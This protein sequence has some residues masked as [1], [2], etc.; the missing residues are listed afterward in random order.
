MNSAAVSRFFR[1]RPFLIALCFALLVFIA[2]AVRD[3]MGLQENF[4]TKG[5]D[6]IMRLVTVRDWLA[7]QGWFDSTQY[8]ILP[9]EGMPLHWSRYIDAG[10]AAIILPLTLFVPME[11][12][13]QIA[14][15]IW[16]TLIF[17]LNLFV[18]AYGTRRL[19]GTWAACS[20]MLCMVF[21]PL[22]GDLHSGAGNLDHH[23]VQ[24]LM[25]SIVAL[26]I[27]WPERAVRAGLIG[28]VAAAFS[29][30]VGL[31]SLP[32]VVCAGALVLINAILSGTQHGRQLL[33]SF[34]AALGASSIVFWLGQTVPSE[35]FNP[36]CDRLAT[37]T[38]ALVGIAVVA[39]VLPFMF[40]RL[41]S[42]PL[43][44]ISATVALTAIGVLIAWPLLSPCL[45]GP[46]GQLP[47]E[48][49]D[50]I[51]GK[52]TE[53]KPIL[54]Y[55]VERPGAT[56]VFFLP[57]IVAVCFGTVLWLKGRHAPQSDESNTAALGP[58]LV[59]ILAGIAMTFVQM[60]T[61]II[62]GSVVPIVGGY[63]I[64]RFL[65]AYLR[66]RQLTPALV[67]L[68]VALSL[69]SPSTI[70]GPLWPLLRTD[71]ADSSDA[72]NDC[73]SYASLNTL[74]EVPPALVLTHINFG[75]ALIWA[76]HHFGLAAPYHRSPAAFTN[77]IVPFTFAEEEME[78]YVRN[79]GATHL[80][81][82]RGYGYESAFVSDLATGGSVDWLRR[83]VVSNDAQLLFEVLP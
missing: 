60:R 43:L 48:V 45:G 41:L 18:I 59:L 66:E 78:S 9:P 52:I 71:N 72:G 75:P 61:V 6:D 23:N 64:S 5:N 35:L 25:M 20:A 54:V 67:G 58:L 56:L 32:F 28:G 31:E 42:K 39:S 49:Q 27:V 50:L 44:Q 73:R 30:T 15:T 57:V 79:T 83:V 74:N 65:K 68:A 29:I 8:R 70:I 22:T 46:Y 1:E 12:A 51:S 77:G 62:A 76:T 38:L 33:L 11:L 81:L 40:G 34:C 14:V 17:I 24:M 69:I 19:F 82:C 13:E 2:K 37:P 80:L 47:Q 4:A 55:G 16:P 7:G 26:A 53:A 36:A 63:I 3:G 10:I 21:W